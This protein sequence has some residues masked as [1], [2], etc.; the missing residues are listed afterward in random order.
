MCLV[1]LLCTSETNTK[2]SQ[3]KTTKHNTENMY[4]DVKV[5]ILRSLMIAQHESLFHNPVIVLSTFFVV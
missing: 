3:F 2:S 4:C 1:N 5:R